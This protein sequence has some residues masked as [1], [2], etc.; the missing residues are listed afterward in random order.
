[1]LEAQGCSGLETKAGDRWPVGQSPWSQNRWG[2]SPN[3][4]SI[5]GKEGL[6]G[7]APGPWLG[8]GVGGITWGVVTLSG[9]APRGQSR[10]RISIPYI[11]MEPVGKRRHPI[12]WLCSV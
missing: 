10:S 11:G 5:L 1:M 8:L 7:K 9:E 3:E 12:G 2:S 6:G 4:A